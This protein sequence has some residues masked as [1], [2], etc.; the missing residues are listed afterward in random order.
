MPRDL[1]TFLDQ[2]T[3]VMR[4]IG[5]S[6][7]QISKGIRRERHLLWEIPVEGEGGRSKIGQGKSSTTLWG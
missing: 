6:K 1:S 7:E 3:C 4:T 5:I 2:K